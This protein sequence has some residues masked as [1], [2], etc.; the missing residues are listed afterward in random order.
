MKEML[1]YLFVAISSL[2]IMGYTVH[3][4]VGGLISEKVEHWLITVVC[5]IVS[6]VMGYMVRDIV[7]QRRS[8]KK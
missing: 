7:V 2:I 5:V 6:G 1:I 8:E 3:M 4:F